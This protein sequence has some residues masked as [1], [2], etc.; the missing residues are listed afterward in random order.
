MN[1]KQI[2]GLVIRVL[3]LVGVL[4]GC[5]YLVSIVYFLMGVHPEGYTLYHYL[6]AGVVTLA[7]GLYFL[8]GAP[9]IVR[10]AY[11]DDE[12]KAAG[13]DEGSL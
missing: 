7:L 6:V 2:F 3:G 8:R 9:H 12:K 5:S 4:W 1:E 11:P 10:F 13:R